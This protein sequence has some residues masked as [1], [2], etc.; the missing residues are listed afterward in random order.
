[1]E[2]HKE[3]QAKCQI[4]MPE[5]SISCSVSYVERDGDWKQY[6]NLPTCQFASQMLDDFDLDTVFLAKS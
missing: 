1:M 3:C 2:R 6:F 4:R 5:R